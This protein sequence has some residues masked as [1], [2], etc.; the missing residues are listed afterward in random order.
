MGE[1]RSCDG[2]DVTCRAENTYFPALYREFADPCPRRRLPGR[3]LL[4]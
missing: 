1:L 4:A 3:L 2:D